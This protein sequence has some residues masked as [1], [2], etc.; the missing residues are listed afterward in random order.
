MALTGD[1]SVDILVNTVL[2]HHWFAN[3]HFETSQT[4]TQFSKFVLCHQM[5][6]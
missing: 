1:V 3:D 4:T 6:F 2:D 5:A